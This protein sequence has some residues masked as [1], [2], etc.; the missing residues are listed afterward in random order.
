MKLA[1]LGYVPPPT[2]GHPAAF[3]ANVRKF[4]CR[5]DLLLYSDH[6]WPGT[7]RLKGSPEALKGARFPNGEPNKFAI[8]NACFF[9]GLRI[10]RAHG[11]TH[12]I[13]LEEDSRVGRDDWD[14]VMWEEYFSIGRPL[15]AAGTLACYNPFNFS[16]EAAARWRELLRRNLKKNFPIVTYGWLGAGVK[17]PSC[18]FP[19]G[20]LAIY[21]MVWMAKLFDLDRTMDISRIETA[22]DMAVGFKVWEVF[23]ESS[24]DVVGFMDSI[25]SGYKD[26][27]TD[28][29]MRRDMLTSGKVVAVHQIKSDWA[30]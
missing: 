19:N 27:V 22:W 17:G 14:Q 10:A 1:V 7:L 3:I 30:P 6:D 15:I 26:L 20:A 16:I 8:P 28:E 13:M 23:N 4:K 18:I 5:T 12:V 24:Y 11:Y 2:V 29:A 9:T 25:F 21:D